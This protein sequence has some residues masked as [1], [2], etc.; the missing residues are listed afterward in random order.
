MSISVNMSNAIEMWP[1]ERLVPYSRNART[2]SAE[3]VSRIA[4]SIVEF[5]FTNPLLVGDVAVKRWLLKFPHTMPMLK[6]TGQTWPEVVKE[7]EH[8]GKMAR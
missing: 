1:V 4:A 3:Q 5:G 2:H 7:R 8:D 6:A